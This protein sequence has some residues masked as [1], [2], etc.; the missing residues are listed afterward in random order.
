MI[1]S[2]FFSFLFLSTVIVFVL[3]N[4]CW[5]RRHHPT[6]TPTDTPTPADTPTFTPTPQPLSWTGEKFYTFDAMWGSKGSGLDQ[7]SD[8][9]GVQIGSDG[10]MVIADAGNNR[11][12]IWNEDGKPLTAYG[13]FGTNAVWRNPPQFNHPS[14]LYVDSSK[15]IFVADTLNHRVV[16]LDEHGLVVSSWGS[17][18]VTN[19]LFNMPRG[20]VKDHYGNIWVLD[21]GNSRIQNFSRL[22]IFQFAWG[23][24]GSDPGLLNLPIGIALNFIDQA[25]IADTGNFR[26]QVFND[27]SS[28]TTNTAPVTVEGWYGE[29]PCQFKEPAGVVITHTGPIAVVDGLTGR[30]E[31][32]N[33]RFEF[34]GQWRAKDDILNQSY[35]PHFRGIACDSQD[36]LYVT[37]IH[38]NAI[39]RSRLIKARADQATPTPPV[40]TPTPVDTNPYGGVGYPIR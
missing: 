26:L 24:Y 2:Y 35:A 5:A 10:K 13:A 39:I 25:I 38:N 7:L 14:G 22:G 32:F 31:F 37:D 30:V 11:I 29:G 15:N 34:I 36:R 6:V 17:Q 12:L 4:P 21:T 1:R 16:V 27:Q 28:A 23:L 9:E 19:G 20:I 40:P 8:P 3:P 18:G 33:N